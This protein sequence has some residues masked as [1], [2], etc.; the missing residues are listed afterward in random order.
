MPLVQR[1]GRSWWAIRAAVVCRPLRN[2]F[3]LCCKPAGEE[4]ASAPSLRVGL[5]NSGL[6]LSSVSGLVWFSTLKVPVL[7]M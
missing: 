6:C 2:Y 1:R 4:W 7:P 3:E 5:S